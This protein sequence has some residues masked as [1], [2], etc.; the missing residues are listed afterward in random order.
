[1]DRAPR[2]RN[3]PRGQQRGR[4]AG[5]KGRVPG[6]ARRWSRHGRDGRQRHRRSRRLRLHRGAR[7][8]GVAGL[9]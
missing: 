1:M 8:G 2:R 3:G 5:A 6:A 4:A 9:G 7:E